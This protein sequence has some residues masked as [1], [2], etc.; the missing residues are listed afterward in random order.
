[1][2]TCEITDFFKDATDPNKKGKYVYFHRSVR[3]K[4]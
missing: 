1:M 2:M 4:G 3:K